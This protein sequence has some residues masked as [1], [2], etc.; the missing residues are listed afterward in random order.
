[1]G[2]LFTKITQTPAVV[3]GRMAGQFAKPRT[4]LY[5]IVGG[6]KIALILLDLPIILF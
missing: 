6:S 4:E 1:L 2:N 5:E 3:I